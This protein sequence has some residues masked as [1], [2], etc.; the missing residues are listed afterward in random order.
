MYVKIVKMGTTTTVAQL[1]DQRTG[2]THSFKSG[3]F[4]VGKVPTFLRNYMVEQLINAPHVYQGLMQVILGMSIV[5]N[6]T[7]ERSK[8][9]SVSPL[10]V[11]AQK[12]QFLRRVVPSS[13]IFVLL[14]SAA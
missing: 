12:G 8:P 11:S 9:L 6:V 10:V 14:A 4:L 13:A 1:F 2:P 3:A 5:L 7:L